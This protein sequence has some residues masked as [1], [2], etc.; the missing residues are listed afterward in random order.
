MRGVEVEME[1][2][3]PYVRHK[4][5]DHAESVPA[6]RMVFHGTARHARYRLYA[7]ITP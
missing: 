4:P 5:R 3:D 6:M 1:A 2:G 7:M